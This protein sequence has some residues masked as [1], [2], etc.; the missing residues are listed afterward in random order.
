MAKYKI[1]YAP[2]DLQGDIPCLEFSLIDEVRSF[3]SS[4]VYPIRMVNEKI[5]VVAIQ[6][7]IIVTE[8]GLFIDDLF[9][10]QFFSVYPFYECDE[11]HIQEYLSYE[12]AYK[13]ALEMREPNRL[14]YDNNTDKNYPIENIKIQ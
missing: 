9:N 3:I 4:I 1:Y 12:E 6:D 13:I 5:Y 10:K 2:V 11:I 14:C 7:E 8:N